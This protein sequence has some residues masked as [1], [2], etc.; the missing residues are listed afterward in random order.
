MIRSAATRRADASLAE[1]PEPQVSTGLLHN[2]LHH[3]L[4][5]NPAKIRHLSENV[6]RRGGNPSLPVRDELSA[7]IAELTGQ[8][9]LSEA[10][11]DTVLTDQ[12]TKR[13]KS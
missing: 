9:G 3:G 6:H 12:G 11:G 7:A 4:L 8:L 10:G 13:D 2:D 5:G 1:E